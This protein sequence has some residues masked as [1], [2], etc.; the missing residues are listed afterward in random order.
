MDTL[1][2]RF[3]ANRPGMEI[4]CYFTRPGVA[5]ENCESPRMQPCRDSMVSGML[6]LQG[7]LTNDIWADLWTVSSYSQSLCCVFFPTDMHAGHIIPLYQYT[8]SLILKPLPGYIFSVA[9]RYNLG[10]AWEQDY[11]IH[12]AHHRSVNSIPRYISWF[13]NLVQFDY[14]PCIFPCIMETEIWNAGNKSVPY[15]C[16]QMWFLGLVMFSIFFY[17]L[18]CISIQL[19]FL[20]LPL[21]APFTTTRFLWLCPLY[22]HSSWLLQ[23]TGC[24]LGPSEEWKSCHQKQ[25]PCA[26]GWHILCRGQEK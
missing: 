12:V 11:T 6:S 4:Y 2:A 21:H 19:L 25:D 17:P 10:G 23:T 7:W 3:V 20:S 15:T 16:T 8:C 9:A 5:R 24:S 1:T 14:N 13:Q 22:Q 26:Q 18:L